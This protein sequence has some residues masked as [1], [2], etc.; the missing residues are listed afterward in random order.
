MEAL[1][2]REEYE[3]RG[4]VGVCVGECVYRDCLCV[5]VCV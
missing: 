2:R 3:V 5:S 1:K 4:R